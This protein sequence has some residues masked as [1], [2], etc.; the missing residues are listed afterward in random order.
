MNYKLLIGWVDLPPHTHTS[1]YR[2]CGLHR[3]TNYP[4]HTDRD[5][6]IG[7][8]TALML[9]QQGEPTQPTAAIQVIGRRTVT[10]VPP[11]SFTA[12]DSPPFERR[13]T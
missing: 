1:G 2:L 13:T 9:R 8:E 12:N 3:N 10:V 7:S 5:R 11:E 4:E 6:Q